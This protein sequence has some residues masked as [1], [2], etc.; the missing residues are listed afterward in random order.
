MVR[1]CVIATLLCFLTVL[2]CVPKID[3]QLEEAVQSEAAE[4]NSIIH[5]IEILEDS[6]TYPA[7]IS[8]K[9]YIPQ[10]WVYEI[11]EPTG[12]QFT[13]YLGI[14]VPKDE[15]RGMKL[16]KSAEGWNYYTRGGS[17]T[18][19]TKR[20]IVSIYG[21]TTRMANMQGVPP[22]W[23]QYPKRISVD[24]IK[25][26]IIVESPYYIPQEATHG[27]YILTWNEFRNSRSSYGISQLASDLSTADPYSEKAVN[28]TPDTQ[29]FLNTVKQ[30][31]D[32]VVA[33]DK[34][35]TYAHGCICVGLEGKYSKT[36]SESWNVGDAISDFSKMIDKNKSTMTQIQ[37]HC[38]SLI[39]WG[40][41]N[42]EQHNASKAK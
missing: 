19:S 35:L 24:Y 27:V 2:S 30:L 8:L 26:N 14:P 41:S 1:N 5:D 7:D 25:G 22:D 4:M 23:T 38:D 29:K 28:E 6:I 40:F 11:Q 3:T 16:A 42:L 13:L 18:P 31:S 21:G 32:G 33:L 36:C 20:Y 37:A 9:D 15:G 12:K 34:D 17:L 39:A 10:S